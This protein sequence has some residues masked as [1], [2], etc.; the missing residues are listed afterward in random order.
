MKR[1][2]SIQLVA[3]SAASVTAIARAETPP[4]LGEPV[5]LIQLEA[6]QPHRNRISVSYRMG[7]NITADFKKLGGFTAL[8]NPGSAAGGAVDRTYDNGYNRVDVTG[9][10]HGP[11]FENTTWNWGYSDPSSIQGNTMVLSSS[12][13][14][15][16]ASSKNNSDDPQHGFEITYDRELLQKGA[17]KFG[18]EGAMG[19][20]RISISDSHRLTATVNRI[21]DTFSIGSGVVVPPAPYSGTFNGPGPVIGSEPGQRTTSV[22]S[23]STDTIVGERSFDADV[24]GFRLGPYAEVPLN[25]KFSLLFSGGLYLAVG[26]SEFKFHETVTIEGVGTETHSGSSSQTDFLVGGYIGG[27]VEYALTTDVGLFVGAQFQSAGQTVNK[28]KG[29]EAVLNM[30]ESVVVT[31]GVSYSF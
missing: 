10:N 21:T 2:R 18:V 30:G 8:S 22:V 31:F 5:P 20:T 3:L 27:N 16:T 6:P 12:S 15:A 25:D 14:P 29:K 19:Y 13:S 17:W 23:S 26:N 11:G 1:F 24:F 7:L 28:S 4:V 9:N